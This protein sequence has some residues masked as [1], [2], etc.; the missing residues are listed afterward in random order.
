MNDL[1][2]R[3]TFKA[4]ADATKKRNPA[5]TFDK[6]LM[7]AAFRN[8][9]A[10]LP[11]K[12]TLSANAPRGGPRTLDAMLSRVS[13]SCI[14]HRHTLLTSIVSGSRTGR[15]L[16]IQV[17]QGNVSVD[18]SLV[19]LPIVSIVRAAADCR[20]NC[21]RDENSTVKMASRLSDIIVLVMRQATMRSCMFL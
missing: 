14:L 18:K 11:R 1:W 19:M 17:I 15:V 12:T 10:R 5:V 7:D 4:F 8:A 20:L 16:G 21:L 3:Q 9:I 13:Q 2:A 6:V